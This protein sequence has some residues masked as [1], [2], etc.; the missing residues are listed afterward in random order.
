[1]PAGQR[2]CFWYMSLYRKPV[3][4]VEEV[5]AVVTATATKLGL[6]VY[7]F[8]GHLREITLRLQELTNST[9]QKGKMF[10][11]VILFTDI[12]VRVGQPMG[13]YGQANLNLIIANW[14]EQKYT[15]TERLEKVF[16]PILYPIKKEFL[17]QFYKH[18]NFTFPGELQYTEIDRYYYGSTIENKNVFN[19]YV[20]CIEIQNL[21][22]TINNKTC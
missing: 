6:P 19:D 20:D 4:I 3:Y 21:Q 2:K 10:P 1:M 14:T 22:V 8:F 11:A 12:P 18:I 5:A 16:K 15:S 17:N 7:Y 9:T 13:F